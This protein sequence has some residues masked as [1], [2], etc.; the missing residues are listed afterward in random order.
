ME[1][2]LYTTGRCDHRRP[3]GEMRGN[4]LCKWNVR[5]RDSCLQ[6]VL[7]YGDA[8]YKGLYGN[9]TGLKTLHNGLKRREITK[10]TTGKQGKSALF[11]EH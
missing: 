10:N 9:F 2:P 8:I 3:K 6:A 11:T 1:W 7:C 4:N 5:E